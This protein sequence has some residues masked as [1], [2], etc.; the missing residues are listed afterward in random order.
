[1]WKK[2]GLKKGVWKDG[3][4]KISYCYSNGVEETLLLM[5]YKCDLWSKQ[6]IRHEKTVYVAFKNK[7]GVMEH[8]FVSVVYLEL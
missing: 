1:M 5:G 3:C 4:V 8:W 6:K 2:K 7:T